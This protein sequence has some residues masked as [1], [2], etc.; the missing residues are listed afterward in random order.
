VLHDAGYYTALIGKWDSGRARRFLPRQRGFDYYYGFA[1]TGI[2]YYTH[3]RYGIAS[4]FRNNERITEQGH[5][6]DLFRREAL[7]V[8][9]K[10]SDSPF[11]LYLAFNAPHIASTFD[12]KAHQVPDKYLTM[13]APPG[14]AY[15]RKVEYPALVTQ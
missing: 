10:H 5:A 7:R 2:D 8:I 11:F 1:N 12:K 4:L 6:T 15:S 13:Y 3:E 14:T 9:D